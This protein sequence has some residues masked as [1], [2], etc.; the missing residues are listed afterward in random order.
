MKHYF[1]LASLL[2]GLSLAGC[3]SQKSNQSMQ[4]TVTKAEFGQLPDGQ[5]ASLYTLT[6]ANGM[7]VRITNYGGIITHIMVPDKDGNMADVALGFDSLAAYVNGNPFFG[8]LVGRYGN[9]IAKGK[10]N[11]DGQTY[12]MVTNNG[13]NHLH[14][15]KVGF[16]KVIWKTEEMKTD[17]GVGLR[18][19][20]LSKDGEEGYPGNLDVTVTYTLDND[21]GLLIDYKATTDKATVVNL[22]NHSYFNLSGKEG[23]V[24]NHEV[25]LDADSLVA[26]D[27]TLIPTGKLIPVEGTPFD[28]TKPAPIG[29]RIDDMSHE[30][31]KN[32]GGY[33]HCWVINRADQSMVRFATVHEPE[34]GRFMEV[35]TT[36]PG[37]QFYTG[38]F[39]NG[40][41]QGKGKTYNKRSGF[42]L[43]TQH[44][45]D[46]P[47]QPQFPS[48]VL[49]PDEQYHTMT[50]FKFSTK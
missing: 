31:I 13:P 27:A 28:F 7:T 18:M 32:G 4:A 25:M 47:N 11:L 17:E 45:P 1:F 29:D 15:G 33:D 46:S 39:L 8:A 14:G 12:S 26:V 24:L 34:S 22:T 10:F 42:C 2:V 9:R 20:Y 21:N 41:A 6:N 16:D 3:Q 50:R 38:N 19:T 23:T 40:K 35:Y 44:F 30:Q 43:E 5:Q 36:E 48:V 49:R 37:V